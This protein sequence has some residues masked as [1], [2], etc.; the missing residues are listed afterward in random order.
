MIRCSM[1]TTNLPPI[2]PTAF[3][4][5]QANQQ[6]PASTPV[7]STPSGNAS[8][9]PPIDT[10]Q[11]QQWHSQSTPKPTP[12]YT[13]PTLM[14]RL[15]YTAKQMVGTNSALVQGAAQGATTVGTMGAK[16]LNA[17]SGVPVPDSIKA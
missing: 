4:S 2:D 3:S 1:P 10:N 13:S 9:L 14:D 17:Q 16:I 8:A 12:T 6:A 15:N 7:Q 5:Y 11:F